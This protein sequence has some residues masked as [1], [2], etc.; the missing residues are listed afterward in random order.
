MTIQQMLLGAKSAGG[1]AGVEFDLT[2]GSTPAGMTSSYGQSGP[3]LSWSTGVGVAMYGNAGS[4]SYPLR[5]TTAFSGDYLFQL[6]TRIDDSCSDAGVALFN[7]SYTSSS[8][9][10]VW[11]SSSGRI[12][13]QNNC[14]T[15][16]IYGQSSQ[17]NGI[18]SLL[19]PS[20]IGG[21][22]TWITM[23][24]RHL[25]SQSKVQYS[26][27]KAKND[28]T[29]SGQLLQSAI[30]LSDYFSGNYYVGI[31]ADFDSGTTYHSGFRYEQL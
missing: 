1:G 20:N 7:S 3:S 10:W 11:G 17:M 18:S 22:G 29:E 5:L 6:S 25:S 9:N 8:W 15:P 26:V 31:S 21:S 19:D 2:L 4:N 27:T 24:F 12:A 16:Y 13:I 14:P 30:Q 28:W 23:H